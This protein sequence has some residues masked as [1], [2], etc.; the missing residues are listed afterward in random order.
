MRLKLESISEILCIT[1]IEKN[2]TFTAGHG[3]NAHL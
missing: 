2:G 1:D 3:S